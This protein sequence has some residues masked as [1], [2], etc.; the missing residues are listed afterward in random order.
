MHR[1]FPHSLD[2]KLVHKEQFYR[3]LKFGDIKGGTESTVVAV[4]DKALS[5]N[6]FKKNVLKEE[7]EINIHYQKNTEKLLTT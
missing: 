1:K 2:G 6:C 7:I 3:W 5:T 4:Q